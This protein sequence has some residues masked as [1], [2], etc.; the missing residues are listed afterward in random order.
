MRVVFLGTPEAAVPTLR[1]LVDARHDVALVITRP[2]RRRGRG[3]DLVASPVKSAALELGLHVGYR[4]ADIDDVE[5][6]IGVV[7]AYGAIIPS[8]ILAR[9][10][11]LNVHFSLLPRWRGAAPVQRAILA[12]DE[13]TGV[14]IISL[15]ATLDTGP[16]H[17][18]RHASVGE[19]TAQGLTKELS[20][21]GAIALLDVL[22]SPD[23]LAHSSEQAG[24]ATYAEKL[25]KETFRLSLTSV[26]LFLRTVHLGG[27]YLFIDAKR[28][29]VISAHPSIV[30]VAEGVVAR[31]DG[32]VVLGTRDGTVAIEEVRPEG[33]RT[34][35]ALAW[36]AGRRGTDQPR[37]WS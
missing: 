10:P 17:L 12:G 22:A 27:A 5:V 6:D 16:I 3:S 14:S 2:D 21:I 19:K 1:G 29:G 36:W 33:S 4:L 13:E 7:V 28:L 35:S 34:M 31:V 25:T 9:V 8:A 37:T 30:H 18:Q 26:D 23:L 24:E 20:E 11:M 32:E 15:E